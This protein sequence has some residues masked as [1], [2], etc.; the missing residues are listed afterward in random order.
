MGGPVVTL[1]LLRSIG[2]ATAIGL[3]AIPA[4][5]QQPMAAPADTAPEFDSATATYQS[6]ALQALIADAARINALVPG[7]LA[8]YRARVESEMA[9][10]LTDSAGRERTTQ[11]EQIASEV[12]WRAP[13]RYDQRV[14]GYRSQSIGPTFSLMSMFG[15]WTTPTLYGNR[16][17]LGVTA[18]GAGRAQARVPER[19][20]TIH[21]LAPTRETYYTFAGADT[22][23][24]LFSRG[25]R[26]H[27]VS[28]RVTPR[29]D[30]PGD[31]ILFTGDMQLDSDRKQIVRMRGRTVEI[32]GGRPVLASGSGFPGTSGASFM[33][34]VNVEVDGEFWLPAYQRTEFHARFAL[35]GGL[36]AI[37]RI[38]SRFDNY[39]SN[40]SSWTGPETPGAGHH[41][42]FAASDSLSRFRD[43]RWP[44]G[45]ASTDVEY[46]D[47]ADVTP[48]AWTTGGTQ[49]VRFRPE[50]LGDVFRFNRIEGVYTGVALRRDFGEGDS[51]LTVRGSL[52]WAWAESV[53]R[54]SLTVEQRRGVWSGGGRLHRSLAHTNDF[55]LPLSWGATLS[56]LFGSTDNYD[57]LDRRGASLFVTRA[58][59]LQRRSFARLE[60]G[61][62]EDRGV[63]QNV[64]K[65]LFV[66]GDGFRPNRG[67]RP[68]RHVRTVASLELNPHVSGIFVDRGVGARLHYERADG[69]VRWQRL[70]LRT[71][72]R[73]E[74]GPLDLYARGDAGTLLGTAAPQALFEIGRGEGLSAYGY[75]EFAGDH[76]AMARAVLGYTFPVLR[77]PMRVAGSLFIPG[78]APGLAAGIHTAWTDI[79]SE[80]A[81]QAVLELGSVVNDEG[82]L[83]PVSR[84]TDG[85]RGSA[86]F[87]VTFFGGAL[88]VGITRPIDHAGPWLFTGRVGQ[89]F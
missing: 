42:T 85:V 6:P 18:P 76:A 83:V 47:F 7:R 58:L 8:A 64:S 54:G 68:G 22:V 44:L 3:A 65:G 89:G 75:K 13:Y 33:E 11:I 10:A 56:A 46:A 88:V 87:L 32:R 82:V 40:D 25:R 39:R 43:W 28:V 53:A 26:I 5:A 71:A 77:A 61:A 79:S 84:S 81:E 45:H 19:G 52:G 66:E 59:G 49:R 29:S 38:V 9:L 70:E 69:D 24:V 21:P 23:V 20:L 78:L 16:L 27:V 62:S 14:V 80:E 12:R 67:I 36:R 31:A 34:L 51:A 74:L 55:Q 41:L 50:T 37:V 73:R 17:Q 4:P 57:Y 1:R 15:G 30:A 35:L 48:E 72:V 2:G 63:R 60:V 86:E